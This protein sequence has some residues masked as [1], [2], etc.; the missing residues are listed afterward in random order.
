M[1]NRLNLK[2]VNNSFAPF[3]IPFS[4]Q[5]LTHRGAGV[6]LAHRIEVAIDVGGGAHIAMPQPFLYLLHRYTLGKKH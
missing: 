5:R 1:S 3:V 2:G 4:P 6:C